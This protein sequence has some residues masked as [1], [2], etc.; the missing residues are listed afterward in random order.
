M[1][2]VGYILA[3]LLSFYLLAQICDTYFVPALEKIAIKLKMSSDVAGATLMAIG[4]SA[5]ELFIAII[6]IIMPSEEAGGHVDIG[7]GTIVGS[8]LFNI[9]VIVGAVAVVKKAVL[10][11]QPIVRDIIFYSITIIV[12]LLAFSDGEISLW[13]SMIFVGI[14]LIY[15]FSVFNWRKW[16]P[17]K[18]RGSFD[19]DEDD[20]DDDNSQKKAYYTK[21]GY[22]I[23]PIDY[24][25]GLFFPKKVGDYYIFSMSILIIAALCWVLV[26]SAVHVS[27]IL[28]IPEIIIAL[29]VLA[30]GTSV[31]DLISSVIVAKQGKGGMAISNAFGSNIFDILIG[32]GLPWMILLLFSNR[33]IPVEKDNLIVSIALLFGSVAVVFLILYLKKWRVRP[34]T[35]YI[36]ISIYLVYLIWQIVLAYI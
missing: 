36:L 25:I 21:L 34:R 5:P 18:D 16:F 26:E 8:A 24:V 33:A 10:S 1:E 7:I 15:L 22:I 29:T 32:L 6:A 12:L 3:L 19:E 4:S 11:W 23:R 30:I 35:G 2:L 31:P 20:D 14:Y 13:N 27:L 17:Y 9:L 28:G